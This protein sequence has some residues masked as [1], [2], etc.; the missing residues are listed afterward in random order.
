MKKASIG[1]FDS[2]LGGLTVLQQLQQKLPNESFV[3][4]GDT[5]HVP[6]GNKSDDAIIDYSYVL[7]QF[8]IKQHSVKMIIIA[9]NT[10][11]AITLQS[12][13]RQNTIPIL[14]V[15][16]PMQKLL[17]EHNNI[18]KRARTIIVFTGYFTIIG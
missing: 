1:I 15:I 7:S 14:D 17:S 10:A 5:A 16:T 8:L 18:T 9:C 11:S 12:L 2:G 4:I 13:Q 6:Y 3:Y